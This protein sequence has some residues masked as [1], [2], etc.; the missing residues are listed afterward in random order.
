V[1]WLVNGKERFRVD[2]IGRRIDEE[3]LTLDHGG[4]EEVVEPKQLDFGMGLFTL[5]DARLPSGTPLVRL[6]TADDFYF[7]PDGEGEFDPADFVDNDSEDHSRLFG[8][9]A[10]LRVERFTV[11]SRRA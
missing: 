3:F 10:E 2:R 7:L 1:R 9:G 6:S 11:K 8:Q 4:D 5:L